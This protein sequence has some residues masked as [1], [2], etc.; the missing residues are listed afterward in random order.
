MLKLFSYDRKHVYVLNREQNN[1]IYRVAADS[2]CYE[3]DLYDEKWKDT[4]EELG[5]YVLDNQV[6]DYLASLEE[7]TAPLIKNIISCLFFVGFYFE[8]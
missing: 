6:E 1:K 2:I 5:K 7:K 4:I 8:R 3:K